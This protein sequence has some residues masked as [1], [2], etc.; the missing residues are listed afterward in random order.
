MREPRPFPG[1]DKL[2]EDDLL[3]IAQAV[4]IVPPTS[5]PI[6]VVEPE[7]IPDELLDTPIDQISYDTRTGALVRVPPQAKGRVPAP[8]TIEDIPEDPVNPPA[9]S[10]FTVPREV[11]EAVF[12]AANEASSIVRLDH[13][14]RDLDQARRA[15]ADV[16][17][18][19]VDHA[20][21]WGQP[22]PHELA[23]RVR[24]LRALEA[25][26]DRLVGAAEARAEARQ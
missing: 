2:T 9:G 3:S 11:V 12:E 13:V 1:A 19:H 4:G 14:E 22:V 26:R 5:A 15:V 17:C 10:R 20:K 8:L 18:E 16:A 21:V 24:H 25:Q 6:P 7:R 23:A